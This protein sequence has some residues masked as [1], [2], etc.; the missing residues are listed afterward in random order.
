MASEGTLL[1]A[2]RDIF[3]H[4]AER[5][6]TPFSIGLWDGS[7]IPLGAHADPDLLIKLA[8][9]GVIGAIV[10]RPNS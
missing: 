5:L 3:G 4:A 1:A 10:R 6:D 2:A 9:P 7:V 8:G